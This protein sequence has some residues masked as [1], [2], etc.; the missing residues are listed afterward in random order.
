MQNLI[1]KLS[2]YGDIVAI[3]FFAMLVF[4]FHN[5][6]NKTTLEH[7]LFCFSIVGLIS[8][9]IYTYI[10]LYSLKIYIDIQMYND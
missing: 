3:P 8:D 2:H 9:I 10:F 4:Y 7:V 1:D 6:K 5:K